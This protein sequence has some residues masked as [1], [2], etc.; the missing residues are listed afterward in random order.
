MMNKEQENK[1]YKSPEEFI[2]YLRE[3]LKL[4]KENKVWT[5][6]EKRKINDFNK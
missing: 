3:K 5:E 2:K 6:E 1:K 4:D